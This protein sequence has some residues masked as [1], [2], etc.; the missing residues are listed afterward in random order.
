MYYLV[1]LFKKKFKKI[2]TDLDIFYSFYNSNKNITITGTN[3]KSTTAKILYEVLK[4]Q[5]FDVRLVGNIGNPIL[6]E[7]IL[8][9]KQFL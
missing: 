9:K 6:L 2:N 3:G 5:K 4:D 7:K 8:Q 1:K